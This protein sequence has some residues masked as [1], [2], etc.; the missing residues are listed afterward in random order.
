MDTVAAGKWAPSSRQVSGLAGVSTGGHC[1]D[2][3]EEI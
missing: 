2:V 1:D 3:I